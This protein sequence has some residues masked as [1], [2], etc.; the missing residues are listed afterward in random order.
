MPK[1]E[2]LKAAE[3]SEFPCRGGG[4]PQKMEIKFFLFRHKERGDSHFL[5]VG[6]KGD[7]S[8]VAPCESSA[9]MK[10]VPAPRSY[11]SN[12]LIEDTGLALER[13]LWAVN[14]ISSLSSVGRSGFLGLLPLQPKEAP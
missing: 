11:S 10:G 2:T 6:S 4:S 9:K 7:E 13:E 8:F 1:P 3:V 14:T 5:F 12:R